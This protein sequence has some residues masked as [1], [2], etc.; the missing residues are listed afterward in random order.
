MLL[1][2]ICFRFNILLEE[3]FGTIDIISEFVSFGIWSH[4]ARLYL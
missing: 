2:K 3:C 4:L 1:R